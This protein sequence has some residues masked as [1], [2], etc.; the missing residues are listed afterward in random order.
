LEQHIGPFGQGF[1]EPLFMLKNVRINSAD[2]LGQKHVRVMVSD[3]EGG[4]RMKAM[5]FGAV[6]SAMGDAFLKQGKQA[7]HLLGHIK[8]NRWQGRESAEFHIKDAVANNP[9]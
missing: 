6:G 1:E 5:A 2:V 3:W 7:F 4:S 8:V 9:S